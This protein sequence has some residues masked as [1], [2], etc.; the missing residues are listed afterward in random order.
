M[1]LVFDGFV[2]LYT[3]NLN[4]EVKPSTELATNSVLVSFTFSK[5]ANVIMP[6]SVH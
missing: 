5:H 6:N 3:L 4:S 2:R 1:N